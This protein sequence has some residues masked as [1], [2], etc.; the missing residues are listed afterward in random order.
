V[1]TLFG[2]RRRWRPTAIAADAT[3]TAHQI[4]SDDEDNSALLFAFEIAFGNG[5][6]FDREPTVP[7][8]TQLIYCTERAIFSQADLR[9]G[10]SAI[11]RV[12]R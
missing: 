7:T 8:L 9:D 2:P 3:M 12:I 11:R 10:P 6:I 5:R 4:D 1:I